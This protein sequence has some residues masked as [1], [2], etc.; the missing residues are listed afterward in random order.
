MS[1]TARSDA[2]TAWRLEGPIAHLAGRELQARLNLAAPGYGLAHL[3]YRGASLE[4]RLLG[5]QIGECDA[6]EPDEAYV[7]GNDLVVVY[8]ETDSQPFSVQVYWSIV[9]AAPIGAA[10][11]DAVVS[12]Q[13]RAWEA[14]PQI[15]V[16]ST[17][18]SGDRVEAVSDAVV[19][20]PHSAEWSYLEATLPGDFTLVPAKVDAGML[21]ARWSF[22]GE[23]MERG[24]IR[25]L[26]LR[27]A[28]APRTGDLDAL[29]RLRAG[30]L[31]EPPPLTA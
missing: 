6:A 16:H 15:H 10:E 3:H 17:V 1:A 27:G 7:R 25:R 11:I 31:A 22:G 13:T 20:R 8:R 28:L 14:Y 2:S 19:L 18:G 23:F 4:G 9:D 30:L 26:R 24:V 21:C 12:I 29:R 5:V